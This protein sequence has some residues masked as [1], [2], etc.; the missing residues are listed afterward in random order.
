[1]R[2][3]V[4]DS[5]RPFAVR[6]AVWLAR[7]FWHYRLINFLIYVP[8]VVSVAPLI[9]ISTS[10]RFARFIGLPSTGLNGVSRA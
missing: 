2:P 8:A 9:S 3:N 5:T 6:E 1:M 7:R 4:A 10:R